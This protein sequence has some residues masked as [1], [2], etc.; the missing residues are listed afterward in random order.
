MAMTKKLGKGAKTMTLKMPKTSPITKKK[1][2]TSPMI[3]KKKPAGLE[4]RAIKAMRAGKG[5]K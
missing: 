4:A 2:T 1:T 3:G 5:G